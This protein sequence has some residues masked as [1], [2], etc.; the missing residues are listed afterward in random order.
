MSLAVAF[1]AVIAGIIVWAA[2]VRKLSTRSWETHGAIVELG[3]YRQTEIPA[4]KIGLFV[5][6]AVVTSLFG[7]FITAYYMR[8]GHGHAAM[9]GHSDWSSIPK[10]RILWANTAVL[11]A[12]SAAMQCARNSAS[13]EALRSQLDLVAPGDSS[14][15]SE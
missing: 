10:P 3:T 1:G 15:R 5:F 6:L 12:A 11:V 7:L 2:L 13:K 8:M 4:A 9:A 14:L